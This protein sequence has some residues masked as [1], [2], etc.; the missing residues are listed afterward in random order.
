MTFPTSKCKL[1]HSLW[2]CLMPRNKKLNTQTS[3]Q[4]SWEKG[5]GWMWKA[6]NVCIQ[7]SMHTCMCKYTTRCKTAL[8]CN[9]SVTVHAQNT[10]HSNILSKLFAFDKNVGPPPHPPK[11]TEMTMESKGWRGGEGVERWGRRCRGRRKDEGLSVHNWPLAGPMSAR[12]CPAR[13][14]T[15]WCPLVRCLCNWPRQCDPGIVCT[16]RGK[17]LHM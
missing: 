11:T 8:V 13:P 3:K 4:V 15:T 17:H 10:V 2:N 5:V 14:S 16:H 1:E 7:I 9:V 6:Q 12:C